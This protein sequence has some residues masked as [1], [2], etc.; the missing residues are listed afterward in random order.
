MRNIATVLAALGFAMV[1][2]AAAVPAQAHDLRDG[3]RGHERHEHEWRGHRWY[4]GYYGYH[5][6]AP[7][8]YLA[9]PGLPFGFAFR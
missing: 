9:V 5:Y 4:P 8:A 1:L 6:Y 2:S 7:S 3:W